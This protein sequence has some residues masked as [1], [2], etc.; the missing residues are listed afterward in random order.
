MRTILILFILFSITKELNAQATWQ[1]TY[2]DTTH[3]GENGNFDT[4]SDGGILM[5]GTTSKSKRSCLKVW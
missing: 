2:Y 1:K 4:L 3:Q 5:Y